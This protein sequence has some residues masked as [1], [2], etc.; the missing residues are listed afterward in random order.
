MKAVINEC[1]GSSSIET[2][3]PLNARLDATKAQACRPMSPILKEDYGR[4][5]PIPKLLGDNPVWEGAGPKLSC[6]CAIP[7]PAFVSPNS[8]LASG[9]KTVGVGSM[10][11]HGGMKLMLRCSA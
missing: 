7:T 3:P 4:T 11:P 1:S 2:C 8:T 9:Y 10:S 6:N 5:G